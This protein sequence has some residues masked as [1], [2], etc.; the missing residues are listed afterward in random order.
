[1]LGID[2][3]ENSLNLPPPRLGTS[4]AAPRGQRGWLPRVVAEKSHCDSVNPS[5]GMGRLLVELR[6]CRWLAVSH[7]EVR[8]TRQRWKQQ[9]RFMGTRCLCLLGVFQSGAYSKTGFVK[10]LPVT[11]SISIHIHL[12]TE[13]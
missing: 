7:T 3:G 13:F 10:H 5:D 1:L 12:H 6:E 4:E 2:S 9:D 8:K 11:P